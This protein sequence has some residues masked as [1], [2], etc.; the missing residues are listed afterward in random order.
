MNIPHNLGIVLEEVEKAG[1]E[2]VENM[3]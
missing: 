1:R 3:P 2:D